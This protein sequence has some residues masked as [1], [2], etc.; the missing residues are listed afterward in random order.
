MAERAP[1]PLAA[2]PALPE[3]RVRLRADLELHTVAPRTWLRLQLGPQ[4]LAG[5]ASILVRGCALPVVPGTTAGHDP[6]IRWLA[7]N[8]WLLESAGDAP[9]LV[10]DAR[11]ALAGR[12]ASLVDVSDSLVA[13][14]LHGA[15]CR[16]LLARGTALEP[17]AFAPGRTT[18]TR[19]ANL[20]VLVRP[21][22]PEAVELVVDRSLARYFHDW[23]VD[24]AR[25]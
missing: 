3:Q 1:L 13:F 23:L 16:E 5:A 21:L 24:A 17:A 22:A 2:T 14:E 9:A 25:Y 18:R 4:E 19:I 11:A 8:G 7:P 20:A 6:L 12:L 15:A 10:A